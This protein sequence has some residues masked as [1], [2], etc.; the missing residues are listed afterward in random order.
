MSECCSPKGNTHEVARTEEQ[1]AEAAPSRDWVKLDF[2]SFRMGSDSSYVYPQDGEGPE[3]LVALDGY[4]IAV[5]A[6]TNAEFS[7]FVAATGYQ[8]DAERFGWSFVFAGQLGDEQLQAHALG[9]AGSSLPWWVGVEG[10]AWHSPLG[11]GSSIADLHDHPVVHISWFDANAYASWAG[12]R[13]PTEAEWERAARGGL[14]GTLFPW[15]DEIQ[16]VGQ[17]LMNIWQGEFPTKNTSEDG[18]YSTAPVRSFPPNSLGLY[19]MTG[20]T[21]EWVSDWYS[22]TWHADGTPETRINPIGPSTGSDKV[23]RGGSYLCHESYCNR[24]RLSAR[25]SSH[26]ETTTSHTG[27]RLA[28]SLG[29]NP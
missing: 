1:F 13:L 20:N 12:A 26:P 14:E 15:G 24:Y 6:V 16:P 4:D 2:G 18:F 28:R 11:P 7:A 8:S 29:A 17:H 3:R 5:T 19:E 27:F 25:T 22:P 21:W 10:A 9:S 23:I